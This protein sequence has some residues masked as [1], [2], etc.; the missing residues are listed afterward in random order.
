[1]TQVQNQQQYPDARQKIP[2]QQPIQNEQ[3][4][5][6]YKDLYQCPPLTRAQLNQPQGQGHL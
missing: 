6:N 2:S 4:T 3:S 5:P 1:M